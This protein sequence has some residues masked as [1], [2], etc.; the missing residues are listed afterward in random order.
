MAPPIDQGSWLPASLEALGTA[1]ILLVTGFIT[2]AYKSNSNLLKK[3]ED[4]TTVL[5]DHEA[6]L[7]VAD[8]HLQHWQDDMDE[9]KGSIE[10]IHTRISTS[11]A[12]VNKKLDR[13]ILKDG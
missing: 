6:R 7:R 1:L 5:A 10:K 13:L 12:Q 11:N 9:I 2:W 3:T 8:A 4:N